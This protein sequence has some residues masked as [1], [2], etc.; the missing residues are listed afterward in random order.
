MHDMRLTRKL[1]S[2]LLISDIPK[3]IFFGLL[4]GIKHFWKKIHLYLGL[5]SYLPMIHLRH[6]IFHW[7]RLMGIL[8][9]YLVFSISITALRWFESKVSDCTFIFQSFTEGH[10]LKFDLILYLS[11]FWKV[12]LRTV[13]LNSI[14][15]F[16]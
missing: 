12:G 6:P 10:A 16:L 5:D 4:K 1:K 2:Y 7:D 9:V 3:D 14:S 8:V 13:Y 11:C 15:I